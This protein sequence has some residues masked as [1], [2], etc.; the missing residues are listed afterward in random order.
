MTKTEFMLIGSRQRLITVTASPTLAIND[1][2]VTQVATA[3]SLGVTIDDNLDWGSHM[4]KIIKKVSFGI[5][6]IKRVRHLVPQATSQLIYQALIHPHFNYCN[7][8]WGNFWIILKNQLQK[9]Q[10]REARVLTFSGY[11]EVAGYLFELLGWKNLA[12]QHEIEKATMVSKSLHGLAAEYLCSRF[13][14][15]ETAYNLRDSENKLCIPLPRTNYYKNSFSYSGAILWN[16]L[17]CNV[18]QAES[19]TKFKCL[20]KQV[21]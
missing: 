11:D 9:V 20:L 10:N 21:L 16:K 3:K 4:K 5:G 17:P 12:R 1:F 7:T 14:T 19:L 6:A 2:R 18:K 13:A 8:V 15:R